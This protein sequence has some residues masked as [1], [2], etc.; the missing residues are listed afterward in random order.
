MDKKNRDSV[1]HVLLGQVN[2]EILRTLLLD[3]T[4]R[5]NVIWATDD[6]V[7]KGYKASDEINVSVVAGFLGSIIQP[8]ILKSEKYQKVRTRKKGEVFTPSW[9]C[10][11]QNNMADEAWF[12]QDN[13][14]NLT[15]GKEWKMQDKQIIFPP[16]RSRS[17]QKYVDSKRLEITCGEAPYLVSRYESVT[18][19]W[20]PIC[21]RIGVLDR[22]IRVVNE[23]TNNFEQWFKWIIR[24]YQSTYG[25]DIQ[26]DNILI[27]RMNLL[28]TF[29]EAIEE[30]WKRRPTIQ[31]VKTIARIISWN[32]WQM[33]AFTFCIPKPGIDKTNW[34]DLF[35][36]IEDETNSMPT[37]CKITDWRYKRSL[38]VVALKETYWKEKCAMKFDVVIG[39]PPYQEDTKG[40]GRQA[41]PIYQYFVNESKRISKENVVLIMP[42]RWFAGGMGLEDFRNEMMNDRHVIKLVDYTNAKDCFPNNSVGGGDLLFFVG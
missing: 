40:A 28:L 34:I 17:W 24:A 39:N 12:G 37:Y 29:I 38:P 36:E 9:V 30:R 27:A 13:I 14:F 6:Y 4:T 5:K 33:D 2:T 21:N 3:R 19:E 25:Y 15:W 16:K 11:K 42:S 8:R 20:I 22:K 7:D 35:S 32:I 1:N 18:G 41:R 23:N 31:E 10:N 26:G